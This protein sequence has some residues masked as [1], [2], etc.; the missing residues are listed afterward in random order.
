M[1][2]KNGT[3]FAHHVVCFGLVEATALTEVASTEVVKGSGGG[4]RSTAKQR[5]EERGE[6]RWIIYCLWP[7]SWRHKR[8][9]GHREAWAKKVGVESAPCCVLQPSARCAPY[10]F[11]PYLRFGR[12]ILDICLI[13]TRFCKGSLVPH[14]SPVFP[15]LTHTRFWIRSTVTNWTPDFHTWRIHFLDRVFSPTI[16]PSFPCLTYMSFGKG[17]QTQIGP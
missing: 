13:D 16:E 8:Q 4:G 17:L 5:L 15:Y 14:C 11:S 3:D 12:S 2:Y 1:Q 6:W 7:L 9:V 10:P